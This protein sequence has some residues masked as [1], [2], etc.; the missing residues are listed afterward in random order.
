MPKWIGNR[1]GNMIPISNGGEAASS[2][3]SIFDQFYAQQQSGWVPSGISATGGNSTSEYSDG[4]NSYKAHIFTSSGSLV[5]DSAPGVATVDV[6]IVAGGGGGGKG[7]FSNANVS[8]GG[9]GAGGLVY[10]PGLPVSASTYQV[11]VGGGG[12][13]NAYTGGFSAFGDDGSAPYQTGSLIAVG[14]GV[15]ADN[16]NVPDANRGGSG[17]GSDDGG[18]GTP[19]IQAAPPNPRNI[20]ADSI[21]YGYGNDGGNGNGEAPAYAG[22]GGGGA[23]AAGQD[24]GPGAPGDGG[25]GR[26]YKLTGPPSSNQPT[27][28]PGPSPGGGYFAGG[29]AGG[30]RWGAPNGIGSAGAGGGGTGTGGGSAGG[31]GT[32]NT[33]GGGGGTGDGGTGGTGGS[34]IVIVRYIV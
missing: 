14:G 32:A 6:L 22:G 25:V 11:A 8:G 7:P 33:G 29:G 27:G 10:R 21:T 26:Q 30:Y 3:Y 15:A 18:T 12:A 23:G 34:G 31:A 5:I 19:G 20:T 13:P 17:G 24:A 2:V 1:F 28:T 16:S 9:G 4:V